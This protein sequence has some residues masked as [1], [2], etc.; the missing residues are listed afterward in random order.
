MIG[1]L[2]HS[3]TN[4]VSIQFRNKLFLPRFVND[5]QWHFSPEKKENCFNQN[6][7][8]SLEMLWQKL[9]KY[10]VANDFL[11]ETR[12]IQPV[13]IS[14]TTQGQ[15]SIYTSFFASFGS[16]LFEGTKKNQNIRPKCYGAV[17][18]NGVFCNCNRA[19]S[20]LH[21]FP[22]TPQQIKMLYR[23]PIRRLFIRKYF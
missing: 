21:R 9:D 2:F 3:A 16:N 4:S 14:A 6:I 17:A 11:H 18:S 22:Y 8:E 15:G 12:K 7:C 1:D 5:R 23:R 20:V 19:L 13:Y 10:F